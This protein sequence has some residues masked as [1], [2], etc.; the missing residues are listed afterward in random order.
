MPFQHVKLALSTRL[1]SYITTHTDSLL[2]VAPIALSLS[3]EFHPFTLHRFSL[4]ACRAAL[5]LGAA[6]LACV[7][8]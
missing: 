3:T 7:G 2:A 5:V 8:L 1:I 4:A 6:D